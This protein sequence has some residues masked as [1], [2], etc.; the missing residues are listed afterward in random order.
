[1]KVLDTAKSLHLQLMII[2]AFV[3]AL[4]DALESI[5]IELPLKRS[6][7]GDSVKVLR[8]QQFKVFGSMDPETS[9]VG[10][11]R[12]NICQTIGVHLVQ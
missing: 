1:M 7:L 12:K 4:R 6:Y 9:S 10:L 2:A 5:E 11:P 8:K 3:R